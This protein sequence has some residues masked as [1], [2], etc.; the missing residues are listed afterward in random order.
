VGD[1]FVRDSRPEN[2]NG[3]AMNDWLAALKLFVRAGRI[4]NFSSAGRELGLSQ[5]SASRVIAA[6]EESIGVTLFNRTTRAVSLT[7]AG[8]RYL[9]RVEAILAEL[10]EAQHEA[11]G[12]G[13]LRGVLRVGSFSSFALR[14][15]IPNLHSFMTK[16]P[17]L[18]VELLSSDRF[19]DLVTEGIDVAF[20]VGPLPDSSA[21][22]RKIMETPRILVASTSYLAE[23]GTPRTP[24]DLSSHAMITATGPCP[25]LS[26]RKDGR[27]ASVRSETPLTV[28][29]DEGAIVG[30]MAGL[31][32][33]A[34]SL[35][36][37][38][39][40]LERGLL[41]PV[42]PDWDPGSIEINAVFSGGKKIKPAARAL[43]DFLQAKLRSFC[44]TS[45]KRR[46]LP[47]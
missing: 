39:D 27:I 46:V 8:E 6:L 11:R 31:G 40:E 3:K 21:I 26:L 43:T 30:A 25:T 14:A 38:L 42:L 15:I 47:Q 4:G 9:C 45:A 23:R 16:H 44:S 17:A 22:A 37:V 12:T 18:K 35:H 28:T 36:S 29:I 10:D 41:V 24:S 32:I 2:L 20:R 7:E 13:E 19:Q 1:E 33:A 34:T 5:P